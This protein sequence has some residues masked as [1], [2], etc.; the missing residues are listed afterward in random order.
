MIA[1]KLVNARWVL[2]RA[3]RDHALRVDAEKLKTVSGALADAAKLALETASSRT[4]CAASKAR[5]RPAISAFF[6]ELILQSK[7]VSSSNAQPPSA[8]RQYERAALICVCHSGERLRRGAGGGRARPVCRLPARRPA[9]RTSLALDLMEELR[10]CFADRFA[11]TCVNTRV[12][13][14]EHF[15]K[16]ESGAVR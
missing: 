6:D 3:T 9:G 4:P 15:E 1:G 7:D 13:R 12:L 2:E 5:Q 8:A 11:L 10:P 16:S 14:P